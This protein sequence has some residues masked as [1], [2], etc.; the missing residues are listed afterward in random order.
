[1]AAQTQYRN[2]HHISF[3]EMSIAHMALWDI[4]ASLE[5]W[6]HLEAEA[7]VKLIRHCQSESI[8]DPVY[9]GQKPHTRTAWLCVSTS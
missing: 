3:W 9:S 5:N 8:I 6:R 7:T 4:E 2:L 1:M